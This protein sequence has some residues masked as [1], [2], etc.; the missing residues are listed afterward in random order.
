[1]NP[2]RL[3]FLL[4]AVLALCPTLAQAAVLTFD[5]SADLV[6]WYRDRYEPAVFEIASFDGD[7]RLHI[8][9]DGSDQQS[10]S[11]Y[12]YQGMKLDFGVS[13]SE[14]ITADLYIDSSWN[15]ANVGIWGTLKTLDGLVSGYPI[16]SWREGA[17][18]ISGFYSFDYFLG[19]WNLLGSGYAEDAWHTLEMRYTGSTMDYYIDGVFAYAFDDIW[20]DGVIAN[21]ILNSYNFGESFDVYWDN[22]GTR[23][24]PEPSTLVLAGLG[25]AGLIRMRRRNRARATT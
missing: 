8:G 23:Q 18:I 4:C 16:I 24:T 7:S 6:G 21:I 3:A 15:S 1:M 17:G 9:I 20:Q 5:S 19:G 10:S 13:V 14:I 11:F 22:V 12:N 25:L 2:R